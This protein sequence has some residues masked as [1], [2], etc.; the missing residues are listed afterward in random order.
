MGQ[1]S[2]Q[3]RTHGHSGIERQESAAEVQRAIAPF[4]GALAA[5]PDRIIFDASVDPVLG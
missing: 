4:A 5:P 1:S 2:T 3:W